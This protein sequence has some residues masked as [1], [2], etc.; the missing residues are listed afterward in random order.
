MIRNYLG[1]W[2]KPLSALLSSL[3]LS[4]P[5]WTGT[6]W[7][8]LFAWFPLLYLEHRLSSLRLIEAFG[9]F[10][11]TF[12][13]WNLGAT[14]WLLYAT[15]ASWGIY[16][17]NGL[18]MAI[19]FWLFHILH[20]K[21]P[22]SRTYGIW[23]L[24][25]LLLEHL[26]R[27]WDM[28]FSWVSLGNA[29]ATIPEWVQW[30]EWTGVAGGS[31]WV[32]LTNLALFHTIKA[33]FPKK[34]V[35][36]LLGLLFFPIL[37][38]YARYFTYSSPHERT[39]KVAIL[40][41]NI[42]PYQ[43]KYTIPVRQQLSKILT[44]MERVADST[45]DWVIAP[46]TAIPVYINEENRLPHKIQ[47]ITRHPQ[48]LSGKTIGLWGASTY[49]FLP[50]NTK[51]SLSV[52]QSK[53]GQ[54]YESYNSALLISQQGIQA[55]YH[56][57]KLALGVEKLPFQN[58]LGIFSVFIVDLGGTVGTLGTQKERSVFAHPQ[59][60]SYAA[61]IICL[62]S[63]FG[64]FVT[65]YVRNGAEFL[66]IIT[67]DGWWEDTPGYRQHVSFSRLRAIENRRDVVRAANTGVSA[68]INQRGDILYASDF[69]QED[70]FH[71]T[72]SLNNQLTFY[73]RWGDY[74][75]RIAI[76]LLVVILLTKIRTYW[77]K[78]KEALT[79]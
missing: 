52:R 2:D 68:H 26:N 14:W 50:Q 21:F 19:F 76:F 17:I 57:S 22:S 28:E 64:E 43:E 41:P 6:A 46:E 71:A 66:A 70:A 60:G 3:L 35:A 49:R 47:A 5:W 16:T 45:T 39:T 29:F 73:S 32:L 53:S 36:V 51:K 10:Y 25:W 40:Q 33:R 42:D 79:R 20:R 31:L 44:L 72:V 18:I 23:V 59:Q 61:P 12:L 1:I 13:L 65:G 63:T 75:S 27:N 77:Q 55:I 58:L 38:S 8:I 24:L 15:S 67:N 69:W 56:K 7:T 34:H 9:W 78:I 74:I 48:F 30:Y 54:P 4:L 62:E 11:L 37:L